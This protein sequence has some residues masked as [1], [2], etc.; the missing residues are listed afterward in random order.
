MNK[1]LQLV[2]RN[3]EGRNVTFSIADPVEP[4]NS[5][6]VEAL[7]DAIVTK[8]MFIT[9]GGEI[10]GKVRA[11]LIARETTDVLEY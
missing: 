4:V 2:F 6:E 3:E 5:V 10:T 8:N 1:T 7:M 11:T 9:N